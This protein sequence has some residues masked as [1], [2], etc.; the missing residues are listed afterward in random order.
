MILRNEFTV[1]APAQRTWR[2]LQDLERVAGC[3]P[4]ATIEPAGEDGAHR[5]TLRLKVGPLR[6]SYGGTVRLLDVDDATRT[7]SF[8]ASAREQ[9]GVGTAA[10][11]I[12]TSVTGGDG[13]GDRE[14]TGGPTAVR[15]ETDLSVTGR[16]AQFGRGMI[17]GV[18]TRTLA[19][20][21]SELQQLLAEDRAPVPAVGDAAATA[22]SAVSGTAGA[23]DATG[24]ADAR[25]V[26]G[27]TA[28]DALDVG[29][30]LRALV[31][32][33]WAA[34]LAG[35]AVAGTAFALGA[36]L[37]GR[38]RRGRRIELSVSLRLR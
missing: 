35:A 31:R 7:V 14:G 18:A 34:A 3:L 19:A 11:V 23:A 12:R 8:D 36:A 10:A 26:A 15:V 9:G 29:A 28:D 22:L 17:E 37:L 24:D 16:A 4:G 21:A 25:R 5:G 32:P 2:T 20:F 33:G 38:R 30:G 27:A 1:D 13:G 6:M